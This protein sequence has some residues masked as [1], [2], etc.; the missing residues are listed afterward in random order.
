M[1]KQTLVIDMDEVM[2]DPT[3][4]M[5][6]YYERDYGL[7]FSEEQLRGKHLRE[8]VIAEHA[9]VFNQ[10]LNSPGFFRD[11][12]VYPDSRNV[13][14]ELNRTYLLFI[15]SAAMEFPNSLKDK[16]DWLQENFP[17]LSWKQIC[18]CGSKSII[19]ADIIIDDHS[20]NF[21]PY[22]RRKILFTAHHN[23]FEEGYER[24][25]DWQEV[26]RKLL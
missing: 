7:R 19:Q 16:Y 10:Y 5:K 6:A 14:E 22:T 12:G 24:V 18:L 1:D 3:S 26:A 13:V 15:V 21:N 4:K 20:R 9:G 8:A 17:F 2:A 23:I 11:L 25:A